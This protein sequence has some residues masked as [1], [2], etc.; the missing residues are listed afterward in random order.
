MKKIIPSILAIVLF[1]IF[2]CSQI[3]VPEN[4]AASFKAKYPSAQKVEWSKESDTEF[5]AE[6]EMNGKEMTANFDTSGKWLVTETKL[7]KDDLPAPVLATLKSQFGDSKVKTAESLEKAGEA[8][9]Y[10]VK[11]EKDGTELEVVL[12]ASGKIIK[13]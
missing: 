11:L 12:D 2:A 1:S 5:E 3:K 7:A 10:E 4:V 6:F 13:K 9:V 8:V